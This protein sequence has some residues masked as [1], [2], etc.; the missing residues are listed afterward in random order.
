MPTTS[1]ITSTATVDSQ[2]DSSSR[3]PT[4]S[5]V[6]PA[7]NEE[8]LIERCLLA[9]ID[10]TRA[11][12]EILVVDNRS[13]DATAAVARRVAA[14]HPE[15]RI[16]V[17]SQGAEQGLVPTRN[18]GFAAATGQVLGRIDADALIDR[19][20][21]ARVATVMAEA[22][23]GAVSGPVAYYDLP[24][25]GG[26]RVS[27]DLARRTLRR[28]G[29]KYPFLFGSNMA[30]RATAWRNIEREACLDHA[31]ILH[32][33]I[34]LSVH[35]HDAGIAVAYEPLMRATIS[36][37]R[38][39]T[40]PKSFRAYTKRF[41]RTYAAHHIDQWYLAVPQRLLQG[42]YWWSRV[43]RVLVP[44]PRRAVAA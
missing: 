19:H 4:V 14:S 42:V 37:R 22:T 16:R 32:E 3:L 41:E 17:L 9:A 10:Q 35:L 20:W 21:V 26:G 18:A 44:A 31:D 8:A 34:D 28:L 27:D 23:V 11:A 13:T 33:D 15:A 6:I 2:D 7:Y 5:I 30:I 12:Y 24:F 1:S 36:A 38:L 25:A 39:S 40:S 43:L 29:R